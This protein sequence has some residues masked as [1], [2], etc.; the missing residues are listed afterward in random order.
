MKIHH[1]AL[2][3]LSTA[4]AAQS[5]VSFGPSSPA[6]DG[7]L[8][9]LLPDGSSASALTSFN[10][11]PAN[12]QLQLTVHNTT[13]IRPGIADAVITRLYFNIPTGTVDT[14]S[15]IDQ[16]GSAGAA[17]TFSVGFDSDAGDNSNP[18]RADCFGAFNV[19]LAAPSP[20]LGIANA[21]TD[22]VCGLKPS[23]WVVGPVTFTLQLTGPGTAGLTSEVFA[24]TPSQLPL[25]RETAVAVKFDAADCTGYATLASDDTCR[26]AVFLR[27][28]ANIGESLEVC[29]TGGN[30]C[31]SRLGCSFLPGPT[32]YKNMIVPI[33]MPTITVLELGD[34]TAPVTELRY[35][36][37]IPLNNIFVGVSLY[38]ANVTYPDN[39]ISQF[40]FSEATSFTIGNALP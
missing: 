38:W 27:G 7:T 9:S 19:R 10:Y 3:L 2:S 14:V 11:D 36:L 30:G 12:G 22:M 31:A 28:D 40:S 18:N 17:P 1:L 35:P 33:G 39:D 37:S 24:A 16:V 13:T 15:I 25:A 23:D 20:N 8:S 6:C 32:L 34:F 4:A 26:T 21:Q 5:L 29:V